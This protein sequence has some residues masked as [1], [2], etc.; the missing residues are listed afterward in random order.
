MSNNKCNSFLTKLFPKIIAKPNYDYNEVNNCAPKPLNIQV[1]VCGTSNCELWYT[2]SKLENYLVGYF[3][4]L[5]RLL[6][7]VDFLLFSDYANSRCQSYDIDTN[8]RSGR[9]R[10]EK[11]AIVNLFEKICLRGGNIFLSLFL[12]F[13]WLVSKSCV[14]YS[15]LWFVCILYIMD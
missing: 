15:K 2:I 12:L 14:S 6:T 5:W 13:P 7:S 9:K 11:D 10:L 4:G 1:W 3:F 8:S